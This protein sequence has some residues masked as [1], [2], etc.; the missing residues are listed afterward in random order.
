MQIINA[1]SFEKL[2]T[3]LRTNFEE[4]KAYELSVGAA[5]NWTK[6]RMNT[7]IN[8]KFIEPILTKL[9]PD[10]FDNDFVIDATAT[11]EGLVEQCIISE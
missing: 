4:T 8:R 9:Y 10:N 5:N 2:I 11:G 7:I 6:L 3:Y 1:E